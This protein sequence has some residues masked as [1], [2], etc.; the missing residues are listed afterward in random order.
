MCYFDAYAALGR[1]I[2][3]PEGQP[4]TA[5]AILAVMD[6]HGVHE[7]LVVGAL[8][9]DANPVV[10]NV[11]LV[12][13]LQGHPRLHPAWCAVMPHSRELPP[14]EELVAQMREQGVL[15]LFLFH[16]IFDIR[17]S[18]WGV[19]ELLAPM[20]EAGVPLF[21]CPEGGGSQAG[22]N[23]T[24]WENVVRICRAFP[25]LP[26]IVTEH[27]I[28]GSQRA[29]Y[30]A[31][32]A[33]P[34]LYIDIRAVWL[35]GRVEFLCREFGAERLVWSGGMPQLAP[36]VPLMQLNYSNITP[37][38]LELIAGG[39]LRRLFAWNPNFE[40]AGEVKFPEPIDDL[41]RAVRERVDLSDLGVYDCHGHIGT[42]TPNHAIDN[43]LEEMVAE[44]DRFGVELCCVFG[45]EGVFGDERYGN[46]LVADAVRRYPDR[47]I[48]FTMVNPNHGEA[49]M[50]RQLEEGLE[51][52]MQGVKLICSYHGYP[53]EGPLIDVACRFANA[54]RQFILNHD[55]G[56]PAQIE[57]LCATYPEACFFTGHS[58][59][60][61]AEVTR[62][63]PNLFICSCPFHVRGQVEQFVGMYGA[64]RVLFGSDLTDLPIAWG[65]GPIMY[66]RVSEE[67]KRLMLGGNLRRLVGRR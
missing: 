49:E 40:S 29:L 1:N 30:S 7:A 59:S 54:H 9:R 62:K 42:M 15:A 28:Y 12:E 61:Y 46:E 25:E 18:D 57:R 36:G 53:T 10:G 21:L 50:L 44:M 23:A 6:H 63:H 27:R 47:F 26:V 58:A 43:T 17:L 39:N 32:A 55:W 8:A 45:L 5:E 51:L 3:S 14:P 11:R 37:E 48:G 2:H 19:D 60:N 38:E 52:G 24:D 33:C 64:D 35:H 16:R 67:E 31:M 56:S 65:L 4:E 41:H 22:T 66:A 13:E 34:N 20:A